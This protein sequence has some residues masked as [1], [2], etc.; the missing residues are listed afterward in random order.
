MKSVD[1]L[2]YSEDMREW[3]IARFTYEYSARA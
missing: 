3:R 2:C 1:M